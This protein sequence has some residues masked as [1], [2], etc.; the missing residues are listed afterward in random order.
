MIKIKNKNFNAFG[1]LKI[2]PRPGK[3]SSTQYRKQGA[4]QITTRTSGIIFLL[5]HYKYISKKNV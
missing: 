3:D 1:N 4:Q 2:R 5:Q